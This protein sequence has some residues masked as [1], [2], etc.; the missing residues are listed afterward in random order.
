MDLLNLFSPPPFF[1][2][3]KI[4]F[5]IIF[6]IIFCIIL[7]RCFFTCRKTGEDRRQL[8]QASARALEPPPAVYTIPV[9]RPQV[10]RHRPPRYNLPQQCPPPPAYI[11]LMPKPDFPSVPP[12]AYTEVIGSPVNPSAPGQITP[13]CP[14]LPQ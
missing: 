13:S 3:F 9:L 10:Q 7:C 1:R 5:P 6:G 4:V 8:A 14:P 12:P 11:E 2:I